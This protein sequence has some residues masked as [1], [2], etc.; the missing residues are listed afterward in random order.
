MNNEEPNET[1]EQEP[2]MLKAETPYE[3]QKR[4]IQEQKDEEFRINKESNDFLEVH[5][6]DKA[7]ELS[8]IWW[9]HVYQTRGEFLDKKTDG[10]ETSGVPYKLLVK[11]QPTEQ[12]AR[13]WLK[14]GMDK[15]TPEVRQARK[16]RAEERAR[17]E[18]EKWKDPLF[19]DPACHKFM[20]PGDVEKMSVE[21]KA[22]F[23]KQVEEDVR[24][25]RLR[26]TIRKPQN[27]ILPPGFQR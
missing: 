27:L 11:Y 24:I 19:L 10:P 8:K 14:Q 16:E 26:G 15:S 4:L 25:R 7:K 21:Q 12:K 9:K 23:L 1:N 3:E 18:E 22:K 13:K 6:E 2:I 5:G 20:A 17:L